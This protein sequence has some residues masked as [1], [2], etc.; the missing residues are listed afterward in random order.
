[1]RPHEAYAQNKQ[2]SMPRIDLILALYRMALDRLDRATA[3]LT[4]K[5]MESARP[6]LAETQ[7]IVSSLSAGLAGNTETSAA[8][9]FRLYEFVTHSLS[10]GTTA[11]IAAARQVLATLLEGFDA[12]R[13][14]AVALEVEGKIPP[15]DR[16]YQVQLTA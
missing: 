8:N 3:L 2:N 14:Q 16:E 13:D 4:Q 12:V 11:D 1:M 6:F 10:Q 9:F 15:L 5:Q 7:V